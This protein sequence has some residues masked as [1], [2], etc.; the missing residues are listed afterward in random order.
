M[1]SHL[2]SLES[3]V[4]AGFVATADLV[5]LAMTSDP[6]RD[7]LDLVLLGEASDTLLQCTDIWNMWKMHKSRGMGT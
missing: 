7:L 6:L 1:L 4:T 2:F 5:T 3:L